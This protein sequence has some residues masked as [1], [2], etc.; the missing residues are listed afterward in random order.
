MTIE[1]VSIPVSGRVPSILKIVFKY[2]QD[3]VNRL[4]TQINDEVYF[5]G[6]PGPLGTPT[7]GTLTNCTDLPIATGVSGLGTGIAT[8]LATPSSDNLRLSVTDETGTGGA[9]VFA[10]GP[11][12]SS[13]DLATPTFSGLMTGTGS[14]RAHN[15]TSVPAGGTAGAGLLVSSTAN[16][17]IFFGSGAPTLSAAQGSLYIRSNGS[18]TSTRLYVNI[19]GSTLWTSVTTAL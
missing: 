16:F 17:G 7:S 6:I 13:P 4:V 2:I 10:T 14:I 15:G 3:I 18:S 19:N 11:S 8:F 1:R 5:P 9:L 12:L